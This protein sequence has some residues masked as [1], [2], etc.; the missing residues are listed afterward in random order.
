MATFKGK[1]VTLAEAGKKA[2]PGEMNGH[3]KSHIE[4]IT[5]TQNVIAVNDVIELGKIP[6]GAKVKTVQVGCPS[7][8]TAGIFNLG[9]AATEKSVVAPTALATGVDVGGQA[10]NSVLPVFA[11]ALT[12]EKMLIATLT[13]ATTA[14]NNLKLKVW[15]EF[16]VD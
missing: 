12:E 13:E 7:L 8:G 4:E 11:D 2:A 6:R 10:V 5:F 14:A 3:V 1:N 15:V 16:V 9:Y